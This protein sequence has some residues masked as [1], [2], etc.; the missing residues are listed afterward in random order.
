MPVANFDRYQEMLANA[1][2]KKYAYPAINIFNLTSINAALSAFAEKKSDGILQVSFG[3]AEF[4]SG[5]DLKDIYLGS[6]ALANYIHS[7]ADRYPIYVALHTDHCVFERLDS[8]VYPLI[9]E[10]KRRKSNNLPNLF[11]SHMFDGSTVSLKENLKTSKKLLDICAE[12]GIILEIETGV[13]G[14]EEDGVAAEKDAQLYSTPE[15]MLA[16]YEQLGNYQNGLYMLAATF[17]NVHGVYKPGAVKLKP[18][19]LADGQ[20]IIK[21]QFN[22]DN[23]F[24]YVFH[25]GS[26]STLEEIRE[27]INYGV[28]KMN[29]DTDNQYAFTR[30]VADH[31]FK[32]YDGILKVDGDVG[33]KKSYDPRGYLKLAEKSMKARVMEGCDNLLSTGKTVYK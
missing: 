24:N 26:G 33:R 32:N 22:H 1:K 12:L 11:G 20:K 8:F 15:D 30:S 7:V 14:G 16:V 9:E 27:T 25:G 29:I 23:F 2:A 18:S 31:F 17:G 21:D 3:A 10:T 6:L 19:I 5:L 4:A 28:V 13:V